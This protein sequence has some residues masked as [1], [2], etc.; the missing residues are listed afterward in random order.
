[1]IHI[2]HDDTTFTHTIQF[3]DTHELEHIINV[4]M[5]HNANT[6][7]KTTFPQFNVSLQHETIELI[8]VS[9]D[10]LNCVIN[11]ITLMNK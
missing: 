10:T 2:T 4:L 7:D 5:L 8:D 1:M 11:A 9:Y 6:F 3:N